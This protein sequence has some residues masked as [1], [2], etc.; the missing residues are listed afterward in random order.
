MACK[1]GQVNPHIKETKKS[2]ALKNAFVEC[3]LYLP[4][5]PLDS[6]SNSVTQFFPSEVSRSPLPG[7]KQLAKP[8][9]KHIPAQTQSPILF[10]SPEY[11]NIFSTAQ[12]YLQPRFS[13]SLRLFQCALCSCKYHGDSYMTF[14]SNDGN[15]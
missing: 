2:K 5:L 13:R 12:L 4:G 14:L 11:R 7:V 3:F 6:H 9:S 15:Y 1:Y 8:D 10:S